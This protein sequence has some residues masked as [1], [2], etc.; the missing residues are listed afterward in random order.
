M[1]TSH[2]RATQTLMI[3]VKGPGGCSC[4]SRRPMLRITS[5]CRN[6][7]SICHLSRLSCSANSSLQASTS[8]SYDRLSISEALSTNQDW[9]IHISDSRRFI[10]VG[11]T[12]E[13]TI[14]SH[15]SFKD[16]D[17]QQIQVCSQA[18][19]LYLAIYAVAC[20]A[21]PSRCHQSI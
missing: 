11:A 21:R 4:L 8:R 12:A 19:A 6:R 20:P 10:S 9:R 17:A 5:L 15:I 13:L 14:P 1:F 16:Y 7:A 18:S 3:I 2:L